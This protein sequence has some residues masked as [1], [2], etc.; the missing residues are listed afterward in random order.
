MSDGKKI[1]IEITTTSDNAGVEDVKKGLQEVEDGLQDVSHAGDDAADAT[2]GMEENI[3]EISRAQKAQA[4][5]QLA[6]AVGKIGERFRESAREVREF[7]RESADALDQMADRIDKVSTSA[8]ALAMGFA[9]GGPL[10]AAVT[11]LGIGLTTLLDAWQDSE[12]AAMRS[13]AAQ[14]KALEESAAASRAAAADEKERANIFT[15]GAI[16]AG[17]KNELSG[18]QEQTAELQ[19]QLAIIREKRRLQNEVLG[20]E[21]QVKL[22]AVDEEQ[23]S[24]KITGK[25]AEEKRADIEFA[26][27]ERTR[28]Q[29]KE[30][31]LEDARVAQEIAAAKLAEEKKAQDAVDKLTR[32]EQKQSGDLNY[33]TAHAESEIAKI[34]P[35][36]KTGML[37]E[38]DTEFLKATD[39]I[40]ATARSEVAATRKS[41]EEARSILDEA[42]KGSAAAGGKAQEQSDRAGFVFN[43]QDQIGKADQTEAETRRRIREIED[44]KKQQQERDKKARDDEKRREDEAGLG[45]TALG[46]LP[47]GVSEDFARSVQ[48]VAKGLQDGDQGGEIKE[49]TKLMDQLLAAMEKRGMKTEVNLK[50]LSERIK[51]L[52]K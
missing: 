39:T 47:K 4:V 11:A 21:D 32:R 26:A 33:Y 38:S 31:A 3:G 42:R 23:A 19:T 1:P 41:L 14:K 35:D 30:E 5:A 8:S 52:E 2:K 46:L 37:S 22:A 20:A 36:S 24:E 12:I 27:R 34:A 13:G 25:E 17:L 15:N 9:A 51:K 6:Q 10:G 43:A 28:K 45:R 40:L 50:H 29:K 48:K 44:G 16:V 7:D 49:L 18:L